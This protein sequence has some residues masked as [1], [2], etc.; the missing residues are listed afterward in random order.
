[1]VESF[2]ATADYS[3]VSRPVLVSTASEETWPTDERV[4]FLGRWCL[5]Y[6]RRDK[7]SKLDYV[8]A[9]YHWDDR[10]R[11]PHD[12]AYISGV[13]E[14]LLPQLAHLLNEIHGVHY[15]VRYWRIVVGWWLFYFAQIAF[16]RWQVVLDAYSDFPEAK[17]LRIESSDEIPASPDMATFIE[18][19]VD[20]A[21]NE[22]LFADL[23]ERWTSIPVAYV[24]SAAVPIGTVEKSTMVDSVAP[25]R[26]RSFRETGVA[27]HSGY[28]RR[29]KRVKLELLLRQV[30]SIES[31]LPIPKAKADSLQ[32][33]WVL[34]VSDCDQFT[35]VFAELIPKYL[36]TCYLEGYPEALAKAGVDGRKRT[37]RVVMSANAFSSDDRWKMWAGLQCERGAKLVIAQHG[38]H[39]GTAAWSAS[40]MHEIAISDRYLSWGWRD[41]GNPKVRPAPGTKLIGMRRRRP[42]NQGS[43]LQ[44][45]TSFPRQSYWMFSSPVGPQCQGY[46]D[47]QF[48]FA[49]SLSSE[50]RDELIVRLYSS[51]HGW[52][53]E[54]RWQNEEPDIATDDGRGEISDLLDHTRLYVAT[55]N[56]TTFLESFT[57]GI[58]TVMFWNPA[59]WE[60]SESAKPFFDLLRDAKVFFDDPV[61][62]AAHVNSIWEDVPGWW[63]SADVQEAVNK[64]RAQYAFVGP[65]PLRDLKA[66]LTEW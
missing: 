9:R 20:D 57:Q 35:K 45:V 49:A 34:D 7:W 11:I 14:K 21:W 41:P 66:A 15:S 56:A 62:C 1:M 8:V 39:Y 29:S 55:Y 44:V 3:P 59:F 52:D 24:R 32:R 63:D 42:A 30:P 26:S 22:R 51:S 13:Y 10:A 28:L 27:L 18:A 60:L 38:G 36:P 12:L 64:F 48:T 5:R 25:S 53:Q 17:L 47:D 4:V 33:E 40:Q 23:V 6:S 54:Q 46:F 19:M 61:T 58:P 16:D 43:C 65:R 31:N 37:P 2:I 50:V